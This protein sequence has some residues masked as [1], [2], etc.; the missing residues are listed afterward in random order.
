V[1]A[2][3]ER[4]GALAGAYKR[5]LASCRLCRMVALAVFLAVVAIEAVI[6]VPSYTRAENDLMAQIEREG[7]AVVRAHLGAHRPDK[8]AEGFVH[9][10]KMSYGSVLKGGI[11][12]SEIDGRIVGHFGEKPE[13]PLPGAGLTERRKRSADGRY[14]DVAWTPIDLG[15]PATLVARLDATRIGPALDAF[16]LR[17]AGL[18]LL[19]AAFATAVAMIVIGWLVLLPVLSMRDA[20][21]ASAAMPDRPES[22]RVE[23]PGRYEM[24]DLAKSLETML[25]RIAEA[26]RERRQRAEAERERL[27]NWDQLTGLHNRP[28]FLG[29]LASRIGAGN[30]FSAVV[31]DIDR[32]AL[33]NA[34]LGPQ[35]GDAVLAECARRLAHGRNP[36]AKLSR[37][38]PDQFA[39]VIPEP[40]D[41]ADEAAARD[42]LAAIGA[43]ISAAGHDLKVSASLGI[44]RFPEDG[45][46]AEAVINAA[47]LA[48]RSAKADGGG[49]IRFYNSELNDKLKRRHFLERGLEHAVARGQVE[50]HYQPKFE[51]TSRR[52]IGV[53]ALM[54][55]R[56]P[57]QGMI[58]PG[59]FIPL[60]EETGQIAEL[61]LWALKAAATQAAAWRRDGWHDAKVAV[62]LSAV[63]FGDARLAA[64]VKDVLA[65][66]RLPADALELEITESAVVAEPAA[67][68]RKVAE[69]AATGVAFS[70][71]DFGTGSSSL[72]YLKTF[73]VGALKID[74]SFIKDLEEDAEA[75]V[76]MASIVAFGRALGLK[77]VAEGV[78]TEGQMTA[79]VEVGCD[80][81]QGFLLGRPA[82]PAAISAL[83]RN[84]A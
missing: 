75:R 39:F 63:Q 49:R 28:F 16:V 34:T 57:E 56:H 22:Y 3:V 2:T 52:L 71:D 41:G 6:L 30:R 83:F 42:A 48:I 72:A 58:S 73:R 5:A 26:S 68:A 79:L 53:E 59:E 20:A 78:E 81:V 33:V 50:L 61:G 1:V 45:T 35:G 43:P 65:E 40:Q 38:S 27:A 4:I 21:H 55:W 67:A 76:M 9:A 66:A 19:I 14:L 74:R 7:L 24:R 82:P 60:A 80:A 84:A 18:V 11:V 23:R 51:A 54:R 44:A 62:N 32:F 25:G 17:I 77:T 29:C 70:I 31:L 36:G 69:I 47:L 13:L 8:D 10:A 37:I 46:D 15:A 12:R 64:T